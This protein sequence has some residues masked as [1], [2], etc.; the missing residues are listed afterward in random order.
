M[1]KVDVN[2]VLT[3]HDLLTKD[4]KKQLLPEKNSHEDGDGEDENKR[5]INTI[6]QFRGS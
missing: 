2:Y 1:Q 4:T 5:K 3:M 6:E